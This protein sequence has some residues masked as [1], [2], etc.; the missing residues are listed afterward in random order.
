MFELGGWN[1]EC[2]LFKIR[3]KRVRC[4]KSTVHC[5]K[6]CFFFRGQWIWG[7]V[8]SSIVFL[9][10]QILKVLSRLIL[11]WA[12]T[13]NTC[14]FCEWQC[15]IVWTMTEKCMIQE[16]SLH[17]HSEW[18]NKIFSTY[19]YLCVITYKYRHTEIL[20]VWSLLSCIILLEHIFR[21]PESLR[22]PVAMVR[23]PSSTVP[24]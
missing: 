23:C 15:C 12:I 8:M 24:C 3:E 14:T 5:T 2:F 21:T 16:S 20:S 4:Q 17:M 10:C 22:W 6:T 18:Y 13:V 11:N 9:G 1:L 7:G 19:F